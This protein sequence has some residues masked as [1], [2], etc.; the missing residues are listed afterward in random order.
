M[1]QSSSSWFKRDKEKAK[2]NLDIHIVNRGEISKE[3][4][5]LKRK[6]NLI[7]DNLLDETIS[8][9]IYKER[10]SKIE[11]KQSRLLKQLESIE[12]EIANTKNFIDSK[13]E[14]T[15][16]DNLTEFKKIVQKHIQY[17]KVNN[18]FVV[19]KMKGG[20]KYIELVYRGS[21]LFR[22]NKG[23]L[24][25]KPSLKDDIAALRELLNTNND[26]SQKELNEMLKEFELDYLYF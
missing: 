22:F 14:T 23:T 25:L 5:S 6:E 21:E 4:K 9:S 12:I 26:L 8:K 20:F 10:Y 15:N 11:K 18:R 17:V 19:F 16:L 7:L 3:L 2:D 13:V 1:N 24:K